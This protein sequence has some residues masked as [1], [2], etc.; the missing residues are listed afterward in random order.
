MFALLFSFSAHAEDN[1][2][3]EILKRGSIRCGTNLHTPGYAYIGKD[4]KW[5]GFDADICRVFSYAFFDDGESFE[6]VD[7]P[8]D[9]VE[10]ALQTNMI[11]VMLGNVPYSASRSANKNII[12]AGTLYFDRQEFLVK[13]P[14]E[15][16]S[17]LDLVG[18][19][20]CVIER[21]EESYHLETYNRQYNLKLKP[22][23]FSSLKKA[24]EAFWLNRCRMITGGEIY[25]KSMELQM[26][27][28]ETLLIPEDI[29]SYPVYAYVKRTNPSLQNTISWILNGLYLAESYRIAS[30]NV[31][32]FKTSQNASIQNLLGYEPRLW[33]KLNVQPKGFRSALKNVG[34]YAEIYDTNLGDDSELEIMRDEGALIDDD[35]FIVPIPFI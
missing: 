32:L 24:K 13:D 26:K 18:S 33:M 19:T 2:L 22:I 31:D 15:A 4:K 30:D 29:S 16:K 20:V 34:N 23:R 8:A 9:Q 25:L 11:D 27:N 10:K 12:P 21:S 3:Q 35:G 6:L 14:K 7:V 28:S 17:M 5:H 1:A